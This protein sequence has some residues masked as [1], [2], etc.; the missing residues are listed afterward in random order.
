[1]NEFA[2]NKNRTY[3]L[4]WMFWTCLLV[5]GAVSCNDPCDPPDVEKINALYFRLETGEDGFSDE[6]LDNAIMI[7][8]QSF[9]DSVI[10][11]TMEFNGEFFEGSRD[12]LL[13]SRNYPWRGDE[14]A[15]FYPNFDYRFTDP[16]SSFNVLISNIEI[17]GTYF[18]QEDC[19]YQNLKKTFEVDSQQVN[20]TG[21]QEFY[22]LSP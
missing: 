15:P 18:D 9:G 19:D 10:G 20:M 5:M 21:S 1:M 11:D 2:R 16:D 17:E 3:R 13:I 8:F 22:P 6:Q 14:T 7:R 4:K 12:E